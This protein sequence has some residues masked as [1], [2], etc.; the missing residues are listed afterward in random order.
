[1]ES[2][3]CSSVFWC[4][5]LRDKVLQAELCQKLLAKLCLKTWI[6]Q[7]LP[8]GTFGAGD[9]AGNVEIP[10]KHQ[11]TGSTGIR[12][13]LARRINLVAKLKDDRGNTNLV[14]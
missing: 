1:M 12:L 14:S 4:S 9:R 5:L 6:V 13:N 3:S 7:R 8:T 11:A 2:S 10:N